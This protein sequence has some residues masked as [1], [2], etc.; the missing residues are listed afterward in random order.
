MTKEQLIAL[1]TVTIMQ[2]E[3]TF[4]EDYPNEDESDYEI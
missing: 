3:R 1:E 2:A 4:E